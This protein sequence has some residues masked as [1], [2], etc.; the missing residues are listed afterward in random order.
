MSEGARAPT[1]ADWAFWAEQF[2][3]TVEDIEHAPSIELPKHKDQM[4]PE[5]LIRET[6]TETW[7]SAE[8]VGTV[9]DLPDEQRRQ[10]MRELT[11]EQDARLRQ[12]LTLD[13]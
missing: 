5:D 1:E 4:T 12:S 9:I 7:P 3:F 11:P 8:W 2:G 13:E 10:V 6:H